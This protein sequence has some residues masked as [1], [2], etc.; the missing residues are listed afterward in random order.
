MAEE[1]QTPARVPCPV[2]QQAQSVLLDHQTVLF[3]AD[4]VSRDGA[5]PAFVWKSI[6]VVRA[7][8]CLC[9]TQAILTAWNRTEEAL[10]RALEE[11]DG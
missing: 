11:T 2:C 9:E 5:G 4:P 3:E 8:A 10:L 1:S 7:K 6:R